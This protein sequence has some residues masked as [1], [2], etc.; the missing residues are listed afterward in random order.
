HGNGKQP[1]QLSNIADLFN[2]DA[3]LAAGFLRVSFLEVA[4]TNFFGGAMRGTRRPR[5]ARTLGI[6]QTGDALPVGRAG[7]SRSHREFTG[8]FGFGGCSKRASFFM[9]NVHPLDI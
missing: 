3:A 4:G 5:N 8:H 2:I 1:W 7:G 6:V 9:P